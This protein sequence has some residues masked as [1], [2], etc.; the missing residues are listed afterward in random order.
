MELTL[1]QALQAFGTLATDKITI[2]DQNE[3]KIGI[4]TLDQLIKSIKRPEA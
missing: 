4:L 2:V 3:K 1:E